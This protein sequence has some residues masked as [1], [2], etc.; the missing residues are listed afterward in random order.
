MPFYEFWVLYFLQVFYNIPDLLNSIWLNCSSG[1]LG[2][3]SSS[4][5]FVVGGLRAVVVHVPSN[6]NPTTPAPLLILLHGFEEDGPSMEAEYKLASVADTNGI[7][8]LYPSGVIDSLQWRFWKA[9][10]ACCDFLNTG[11][12]DSTY[13]MGLVDSI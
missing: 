6:Y 1:V 9:T 12:D 7:V 13:L 8:Y 4:A 3:F 11:F 2:L 10:D 5:S